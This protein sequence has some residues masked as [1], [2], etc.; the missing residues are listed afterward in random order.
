MRPAA[1]DPAPLRPFFAALRDEIL[2]AWQSGPGYDYD[3]V[4]Y[5]VGYPYREEDVAHVLAWCGRAGERAMLPPVEEVNR[6]LETHEYP[7]HAALAPAG[8]SAHAWSALLHFCDPSYPIY[9]DKAAK[10]LRSL[11]IDTAGPD[12]SPDYRAFLEAVDRLKVEAPVSSIPETNWYLARN[13]GV[14]LEGWLRS[15]PAGAAESAGA[16]ASGG[17]R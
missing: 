5:A 8:V 13:I 14:G 12:G 9:T 3:R 6:M 11:G 10:A 15:R 1:H 7:M 2:A 17:P 16:V 4:I